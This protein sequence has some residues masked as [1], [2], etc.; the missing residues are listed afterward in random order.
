[1]VL[2]I[3]ISINFLKT[4]KQTTPLLKP[5]IFFIHAALKNNHLIGLCQIKLNNYLH[6][7]LPCISSL[8]IKTQKLY[9]LLKN[10]LKT[11]CAIFSKRFV[12]L[13]FLSLLFREI[14]AYILKKLP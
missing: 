7:R 1:M 12:M 2:L 9:W 5:V 10:I 4:L 3:Q 14:S 11:I 8:Q 13:L 6:T